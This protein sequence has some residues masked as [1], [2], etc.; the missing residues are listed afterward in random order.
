MNAEAVQSEGWPRRKLWAM[1]F[2]FFVLHLVCIFWWGEKKPMAVRQPDFD[3]KIVL[4]P[5]SKTEIAGLGNPRLFA[6][7]SQ[8][9]F[10]GSAWMKVPHMNYE[11]GKWEGPTSFLTPVTE[12]LGGILNL[13]VQTNFNRAFDYVGESEPEIEAVP[14]LSMAEGRS[15]LRVEGEL[16]TRPLIESVELKPWPSATIL[17]NSQV[18]VSVDADGTVFSA[19]LVSRSGSKEAD[20]Y[21]LNAARSMRFEP[22]HSD[23]LTPVNLGVMTWGKVVF[24][25]YTVAVPGTNAGGTGP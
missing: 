20:N 16:E 21:A 3:F 18:Q 2:L 17:T 11:V 7:A 14:F 8:E 10:S 22:V 4:A 23:G 9:G 12:Q 15:R 25:W 1:V 6:L 13:F 19:A 5:D 24:E